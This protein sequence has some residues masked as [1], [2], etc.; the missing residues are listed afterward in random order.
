MKAKFHKPQGFQETTTKNTTLKDKVGENKNIEERIKDT[1]NNRS[2]AEALRTK[3][4]SAGQATKTTTSA[5]TEE[6]QL[7]RES[8]VENN[9]E[10]EEDS[11]HKN[12][13]RLNEEL[14]RM[15][16]EERV[17]STSN[18]EILAR[19][20]SQEKLI[21]GLEESET[22]D[23]IAETYVSENSTK[24][25]RSKFNTTKQLERNNLASSRVLHNES[26]ER[27]LEQCRFCFENLAH[28]QLKHLLI[29]FGNF[30]YLSLVRE[31]SL[32]K[33]HCFISTTTHHVSSR[34]LSEE[35]FE[36]VVNFK[37]SLYQMFFETEKKE[38]IFFETCK[39]LQRQKQHLVIDCVPLSRADASECP[40]F[41]KKAIL[42]SESE[43]SDNKKLIETEV[44]I[45]W[46]SLSN[47]NFLIKKS[48]YLH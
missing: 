9:S 2:V 38:V 43:W 19:Y 27:T 25:K 29:S 14:Y 15:L 24:A 32:V 6:R 40:A 36:E 31:G 46:R 3:L 22:E 17:C 18:K 21:K 13:K 44:W 4:K 45:V 16:R 1:K 37:K 48:V 30:T 47:A 5:V 34:Q 7:V 41:F 20:A 10:S 39:D 8:N 33:G 26:F 28:F 11:R 35:I 12:H 23:I 42:E